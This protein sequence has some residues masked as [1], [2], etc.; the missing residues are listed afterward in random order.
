MVPTNRAVPIA[1]GSIAL[2]PQLRIALQA[3]GSGNT[4]SR[5]KS[6]D[7]NVFHA[8]RALR[9]TQ[10]SWYA[11]LWSELLSFPAGKHDD[12]VG[13]LGLVGQLLMLPG[14]KPRVPQQPKS[15]TGYRPI[16]LDER[17]LDW[18]MF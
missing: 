17:P 8:K 18:R 13:A 5:E 3:S 1:F 7:R 6:S 4:T 9:A 12:Q 2:N 11:A 15:D 14:Q 16:G 10:A